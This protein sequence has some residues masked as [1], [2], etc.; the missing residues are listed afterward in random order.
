MGFFPGATRS[1]FLLGLL[2]GLIPLWPTLVSEVCG[3]EHEVLGMSL[4]TSESLPS[5]T[6]EDD[7]RFLPGWHERH[8]FSSTSSI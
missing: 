8:V 4:I 2:N 5:P 6:N 7:Q 1:R 3:K